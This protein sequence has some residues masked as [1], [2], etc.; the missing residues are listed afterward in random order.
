M[1]FLVFKDQ[2]DPLDL[3]DPL[4]PLD[5]KD[6]LDPL[7]LKDPLVLLVEGL[8]THQSGGAVYTRWGKG[9]RQSRA[10][11]EM[12]YTGITAGALQSG[13]GDEANYI[14]DSTME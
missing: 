5:L 6:P 9:Y 12:V 8:S 1:V 4:D 10:G 2:L 11:T 13:Q 3:K 14:P 7:D